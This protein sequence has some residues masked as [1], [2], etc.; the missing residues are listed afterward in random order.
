MALSLIAVQHH[1]AHMASCMA[2]HRLDE[3]VIGVSFDGTGFGTDGAIWGGEFLVGDYR[4]FRRAAHL[5]Y[6]GMPGRTRR[7]RSRGGWRWPICATPAVPSI[8]LRRGSPRRPCGRSRRCSIGVST[9]PQTSS[10]GRL[11]DAVAAITGVRDRVSFEGQAAQQLEWMATEVLPE[12][13]YPFEVATIATLPSDR[14]TQRSPIAFP[15]LAAWEPSARVNVIDTR[16]L[17]RAV[18]ADIASG[19]AAGRIAR[20]FHCSI[21]EII[22][23]A[24]RRI[25]QETQV[26]MVVLTGGAFMNAL[27]ATEAAHGLHQEGFRVF[28]H[29]AVPPNDGGLSLGQIAVAAAVISQT[30]EESAA[31]SNGFPQSALCP[32]YQEE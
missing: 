10:A 22:M 16:P 3:P 13:A 19:T 20:R 18:V 14:T 5:R 23:N 11:F 30:P 31:D 17:I 12:P 26:N 21:V 1:H 27:L 7:S 9:R 29:R 4:Q 32:S 6:V 28:Q 15:N 8:A 24:C 2:E 25:R